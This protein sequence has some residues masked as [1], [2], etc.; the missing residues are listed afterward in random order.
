MGQAITIA[1]NEGIEGVARIEA[2]MHQNIGP[3]LVIPFIQR[4]GTR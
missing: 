3:L 1:D 4:I 2:V